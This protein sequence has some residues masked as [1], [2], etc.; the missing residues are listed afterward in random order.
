[1]KSTRAEWPARED[2]AAIRLRVRRGRALRGPTGHRALRPSRRAHVHGEMGLGHRRG[3]VQDDE[4][5]RIATGIAPPAAALTAGP[6][7]QGDRR[8]KT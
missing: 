5:H 4:A 1:M 7:A 8:T 6:T 2:G 3:A